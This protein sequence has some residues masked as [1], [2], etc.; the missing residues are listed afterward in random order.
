MRSETLKIDRTPEEKA[1]IK[2]IR[3][4]FQ[5][6]RPSLKKLIVIGDCLPAMT[7]G[8]YLERQRRR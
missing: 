7:L 3:A 5:R 2:A 8:A 6:E 4:K 1:R